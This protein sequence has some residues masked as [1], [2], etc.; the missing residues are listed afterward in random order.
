MHRQVPGSDLAYE[1][2]SFDRDGVERDEGGALPSD[3]LAARLARREDPVTDVFLL[4]HGWKG[5]VPAAIEQCDAWIGAMGALQADRDAIRAQV[6]GFTPLI[7]GVH[8]PS[9]P[10]GDEALPGGGRVLGDAADAGGIDIDAQARGYAEVICDTPRGQA[11]VRRILELSIGQPDD[12]PLDAALAHAYDSLRREAGLGGDPDLDGEGEG[13]AWDPD[14]VYAAASGEGARLLGEGGVAD[15][16]LSPL[17]QL[18][19][20][21]MKDRARS[22]GERGVAGLLRKLQAASPQARIHLMG[23]SFGCIVV[24]AAI[25]GE[26]GAP[27]PRPVASAF[28]VQGALSLWAYCADV[29]GTPGYFHRI[30]ADRQV[31]GPIVT[32]RSTHDTAVGRF[33][34]LGARLGGQR[35]LADLP[36][37]G[38]VG[39]YGLQGL[40]AIAHDLQILGSGLDYGFAGG[41]V[42]N[43]EASRVIR[44]GSGASGA[45]SDIAHPE[46]AHAAWQAI[47]AGARGP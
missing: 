21:R 23:H 10:W 13:A 35:T 29:D 28:L 38:G 25:A 45:H 1:L 6:P 26:R 41:R 43:L 31:R 18:S 19:F 17:R 33:Y 24:S 7:V 3:A 15:A 30:V 36:K 27:P 32:T 37:Y 40:G 9:L 16:V 12:G 5:D 4:S 11:L 44:N 14:A 22:V 2:V 42:Y 47:S 39:S 8:W 34:P 46:V 20:W